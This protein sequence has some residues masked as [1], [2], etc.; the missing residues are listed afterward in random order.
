MTGN[1]RDPR[2]PEAPAPRDWRTSGIADDLPAV[3]PE[4]RE[5]AI[6]WR[7]LAAWA[8]APG[9]RPESHLL[10]PPAGRGERTPAPPTACDTAETL[11]NTGLP[12]ARA[13]RDPRTQDDAQG[14]AD[15]LPGGGTADL[16]PRLPGPVLR[17][18]KNG[19]QEKTL[20]PHPKH[21]C[22]DR[23]CERCRS[24]R[25]KAGVITGYRRRN[26]IVKHPRR[27]G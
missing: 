23:S 22:A 10:P 8:P 12:L 6:R 15:R 2:E 19:P 20:G 3:A 9:R 13:N 17:P 24:T 16:G 11:G 7:R 14:A 27:K 18:E 25:A 21:L 5:D 1:W 4:D 26:N